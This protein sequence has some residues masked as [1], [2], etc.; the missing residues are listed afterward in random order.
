MTLS[1][2]ALN[3]L[4]ERGIEIS[5]LAELVLMM[6]KKYDKS[7]TIKECENAIYSVLKKREVV[8]TIL[9]GIAIDEAAENN[10]FD[11]QVNELIIK[12]E[13]LYGL[14]EIL[15]LSI[16]NIYGSIALTNFGYL[17][18]EKPGIIGKLDRK[19]TEDGKCHTYL[20]DIAAALVA[21]ALSRL[22]H[23]KK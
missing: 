8:H 14:D 2:L 15:A 13:P 18:K 20:D 21:A 9:T 7:L 12:D 22:A 10:L 1:E 23:N 19:H 17:D 3:K 6:Q 4:I 16:V 5:E 11:Q